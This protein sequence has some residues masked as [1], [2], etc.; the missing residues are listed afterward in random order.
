MTDKQAAFIDH[1]ILDLNGTQ[2]AIRAGYSSNYAS[3]Q[4]FQLLS[5]P[6]IQAAIKDRRSK[7]AKDAGVDVDWVTRKAQQIA[8]RCM[9]A[10]PVLIF[11]GEEWVPSGEYKFDSAGANKAV[12][13]L[14]KIVGAFEK[15][16]N[17][18]N[19]TRFVTQVQLVSG[20]APPI[21]NS[22]KDINDV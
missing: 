4:A 8:D 21:A 17:Q 13:T 7:L 10:E 22:E 11:D 1:Y 16:N 19:P 20:D 3:Q 18:A 14:A 5:D 2:A 9:Q 12:D 6:D 15:D